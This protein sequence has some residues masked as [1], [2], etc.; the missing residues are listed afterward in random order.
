MIKIK[1]F[2]NIK[3][4]EIFFI[5]NILSSL[6]FLLGL[7]ILSSILIMGAKSISRDYL[8]YLILIAYLSDLFDG[9]FARKLNQISELGKIIDPLADKLFVFAVIIY[10]YLNQLISPLILYI[11]ISRD[12]LIIL[13]SLIFIKK[14]NFVQPSNLIGK[15][16]VFFIGIYILL[17]L[18]IV[19]WV[20]T[21]IFYFEL[22][23]ILMIVFSLFKY[24]KD[25]WQIINSKKVL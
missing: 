2:I 25:G 15:L 17:R 6:R 12:L 9:Y 13:L 4:H 20:T 19:K 21:L 5:S 22:F 18:L 8:Y 14:V 7:F 16:T 23:I 24:I 11:I 3:F 10:L 1:P